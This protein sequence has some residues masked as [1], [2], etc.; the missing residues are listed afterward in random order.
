L[1]CNLIR[2]TTFRKVGDGYICRICNK[3]LAEKDLEGHK[4]SKGHS[5]TYRCLYF[6]GVRTDEMA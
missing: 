4:K 5:D 6:R 2:K 3:R 1:T